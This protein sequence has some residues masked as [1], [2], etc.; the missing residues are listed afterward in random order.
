MGCAEKGHFTG[1][2]IYK[3]GNSIRNSYKQ[4]AAE[5]AKPTR[6]SLARKAKSSSTLHLRLASKS[7]TMRETD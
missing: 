6:W 2:K 4:R 3:K 1:K 7:P 5:P